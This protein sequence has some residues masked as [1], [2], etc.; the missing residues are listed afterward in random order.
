MKNMIQRR[1]SQK[2][3]PKSSLLLL[4][5]CYGAGGRWKEM[6]VYQMLVIEKG[7]TYCQ[8]GRS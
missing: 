1:I 6:F 7:L 3:K 5:T 4:R 2:D 8:Q